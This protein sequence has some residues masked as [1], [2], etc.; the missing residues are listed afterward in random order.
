MVMCIRKDQ[1]VCRSALLWLTGVVL[2]LQYG[3]ATVVPPPT[4]Q[5]MRDDFGV[6]AIIPA[7]YVPDSNFITI[8]KFKEFAKESALY[9]GATAA[10]AFAILT[11]AYPP[12]LIGVIAGTMAAGGMAGSAVA[13]YQETMPAK[14]EEEVRTVV[15]K[16]VAGLDLQNAFAERLMAMVRTEPR[17]QLAVISAA[18][19]DKPGARPD[20]TQLHTDGIDT[21]LEVAVTEIGLS[22]CVTEHDSLECGKNL[23][24]LLH[25]FM[26]AQARLVHVSDGATLSE[27]QFNYQS[28]RRE[29]QQWVENDGRLLGEKLEGAFRDLVGRVYDVVFLI[30]PI[31]LPTPGYAAF[32]LAG[33]D[34]WLVPISPPN[35][36][37]SKS[38]I[39]TLRPTFQWS[40]FPRELDHQKLDPEVLRKIENVTYDLRIWDV[41]SHH[42]SGHFRRNRLFY[43]RT[44]LAAP[45]HTME[46]SLAP[47]TKYVWSVRARFVFVGRPMATRWATRYAV[48]STCFLDD[49]P[50]WGYSNFKTPK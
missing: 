45:E 30:T 20:Y 7:Q 10:L 40:A 27:W 48:E 22:G 19:P 37:F 42:I 8:S 2:V 38:V 24:D 25:L 29:F 4:S 6:M 43:E 11:P 3:C 28:S 32:P 23:R 44:G 16:A 33:N 34:C 9:G 31:D 18:G 12:A 26:N 21:V 36:S 50:E 46:V 13:K 17:N 49:I 15:D 39:D 1:S 5:T 47:A 14:T 41:D 35:P